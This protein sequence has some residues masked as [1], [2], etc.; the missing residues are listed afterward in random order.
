MS[1]NLK[2][3]GVGMAMAAASLAPVVIPMVMKMFGGRRQKI[4]GRGLFPKG[5]WQR[6]KAAKK[7]AFPQKLP[8]GTK[9]SD[10]FLPMKR[11]QMLQQAGRGRKRPKRHGVKACWIRPHTRHRR[12]TRL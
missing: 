2:G 5:L 7:K 6:I 12:N 10:I 9:F 1:S 3:C 8:K 11:L 4:R